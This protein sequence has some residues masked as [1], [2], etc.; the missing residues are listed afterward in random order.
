MNMTPLNTAADDV[1]VDRAGARLAAR[2]PPGRAATWA[3]RVAT[4]LLVAL[5]TLS[6]VANLVRPERVTAMLH[7][8]GYPDYF[9][10]VLGVAKLLGVTA[11]ALP[12]A[13]RLK[14]WAY[15]GMAFD[16]LGAVVS[17]AAV[18]DGLAELAAPLVGLLALTVSYAGHLRRTA[19]LDAGGAP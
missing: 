3:Y 15:A 4:G 18:H 17:H 7:H 9:P 19:L 16:L 14:E 6:G 1:T 5:M 8:L 2:R 10:T 12:G 11:L 13:R